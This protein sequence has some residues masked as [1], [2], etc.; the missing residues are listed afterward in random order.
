MLQ[1]WRL[2][3]YVALI[4]L[5]SIG[6]A[7]E[8]PLFHCLHDPDYEE[9]LAIINHGLP[10]PQRPLH[11]AVI[12][13]GM[14]GLTAAKVLE[15][16]GHKV[17]I[18]EASPRIGGRVETY[19]NESEGW[20]AEMGAMRI[21]SMHRI[22]LALVNKFGL[23]LSPFI[24]ENINTFY[25]VNGLLERTYKVQH[26]PNVLQYHVSESECGKSAEQL[27]NQAIDKIREE[28]KR[29]GCKKT[30]Q[31]YDSFSVKEYL[32]KE[33]NLSSEA[34]RMIGDILNE[35]SFFYT[36]MVEALYLQSDIQDKIVYKEFVGGSDTL[37][38]AFYEALHC[39]ILLNSKVKR[40]TQSPRGVTVYYQD[41]RQ[42]S[43]LS[44]VTADYALVTA[45]AKATLFI[46]F[47]PRLSDIKMEAL[48][49]VHYSS[50]T[51][52]VL[53]FDDKFWEHDGIRGGRSITDRPAR[54][55]YYPSHG[56]S[57]KG[58]ALL[59][60]YTFSDDA[61]LLDGIGDDE[62]MR[63]MLDDLVKIHGEGIRSHWTGGVVKKWGLDPYS[64]GAFAI[65]TP[66]QKTDYASALFQREK[67]I[68]FAGEHTALPHG[69]IETSM[70]SA[71]RAA[72]NINMLAVKGT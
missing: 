4:T 56:F 49:S 2:R 71:L 33:T 67:R 29:A 22:L 37:P 38:N 9:L 3:R 17:T 18:I 31:K 19:R 48:R 47:E 16:A 57:G 11:V 69:W 6:D 28:V 32:V 65:F 23:R 53:S 45:T 54:F 58:G 24:E 5:L 46:E 51:K 30:M 55:I 34:L 42:P 1:S 35:N 12:G 50:S 70:K 40:I 44:H 27:F 41:S 62:L 14:A 43:S 10:P 64:L 63:L 72:R 13:A 21:P 60:S 8:D 66:Y 25:Y 26:N 39:P 61:S 7:K 36:S 20:Y 15:D 59:A 68:H 52:V